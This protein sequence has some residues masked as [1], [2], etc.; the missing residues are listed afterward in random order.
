M[1]HSVK[2]P[3]KTYPSLIRANNG[4]ILSDGRHLITVHWI[5]ATNSKE[6]SVQCIMIYPMDSAIL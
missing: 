6:F 2:V 3:L 5:N 1:T 4:Q